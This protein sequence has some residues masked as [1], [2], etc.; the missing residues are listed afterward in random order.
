MKLHLDIRGTIDLFGPNLEIP[1][2]Q[3]QKEIRQ[4]I[5]KELSHLKPKKKKPV[6]Q[7]QEN[8][9]KHKQKYENS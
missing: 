7:Q 2:L 6:N 3:I 9:L 1:S 5:E 8:E 4:N